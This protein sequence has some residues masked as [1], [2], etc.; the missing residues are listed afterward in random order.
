MKKIFAIALFIGVLSST[1]VWAA[2]DYAQCLS[3]NYQTNDGLIKCANDE[4]NR[5]MNDLDKRYGVV[6][7]H[8]FFRP[9]NDSSHTFADLKTAWLKYRNDYCNLLG[10][11]QLHAK[12]DF[13]RVSEA[14]CK[15]R[16]TQHFRDDIEVLVKNYQKTLKK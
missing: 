2:D 15:L 5:I 10:Y 6:A 16:E 11:S 4:T 8:N 13:G 14:R 9:W 1:S 12:D 7:S 3:L